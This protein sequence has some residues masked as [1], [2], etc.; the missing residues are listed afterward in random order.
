MPLKARI[1]SFQGF[2]FVLQKNSF[3]RSRMDLR[4]NIAQAIVSGALEVSRVSLNPIKFT[5][6]A[7]SGLH[8]SWHNVQLQINW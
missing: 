6:G 1:R 5:Q 2:L 4:M 8:I 3:S 7:R